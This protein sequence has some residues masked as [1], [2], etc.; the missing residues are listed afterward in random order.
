MCSK[1][2]III[3]QTVYGLHVVDWLGITHLRNR[4]ISGIQIDTS[5]SCLPVGGV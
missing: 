2:V 4:V 1:L 3:S 5:P